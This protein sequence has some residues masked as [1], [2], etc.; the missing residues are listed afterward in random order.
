DVAVDPEGG[1][2]SAEGR[3]SRAA[4]EP[5]DERRRLAI[6]AAFVVAAVPYESRVGEQQ[7]IQRALACEGILRS[8]VGVDVIG[9]ARA[10]C[11]QAL[12]P[13]RETLGEPTRRAH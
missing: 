6:R 10:R 11:D 13:D 4:D 7:L 8:D 12:R 2:E 9:K 3:D 1:E 5:L